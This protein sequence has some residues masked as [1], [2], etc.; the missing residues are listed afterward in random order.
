[1]QVKQGCPGGSWCVLV[2]SRPILERTKLVFPQNFQNCKLPYM[3][4]EKEGGSLW[5]GGL[6]LLESYFVN[7]K[8]SKTNF[9]ILIPLGLLGSTLPK[10]NIGECTRVSVQR[11]V[12][13]VANCNRRLLL[14]RK[15]YIISSC[16]CSLTQDSQWSHTLVVAQQ[17]AHQTSHCLAKSNWPVV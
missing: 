2:R 11:A 13:A 8:T 4:R 16:V 10:R 15:R 14:H 12:T 17:V 7:W 9:S 3:E 1:M 6:W 5:Y